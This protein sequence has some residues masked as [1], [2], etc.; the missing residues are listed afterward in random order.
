M[1]FSIAICA[2]CRQPL[3]PAEATGRPR[4]YC[5]DTCRKRAH[6]ARQRSADV[7]EAYAAPG[8]PVPPAELAPPAGSTDDQAAR[9]ILELTWIGGAFARLALEA[10]PEIAWRCEK[11]AALIRAGLDD[12]FPL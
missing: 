12:L 6:R 5:S 9:A 4:R 8:W 1:S 3:P 11:M 2:E 10:R 7:L